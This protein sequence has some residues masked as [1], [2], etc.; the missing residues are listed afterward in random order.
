MFNAAIS[1][2]DRGGKLMFMRKSTEIPKSICNQGFTLI[3]V[4]IAMSIFAIGILAV[5]SMQV[6]AINKY[7][8]ARNSTTVVTVAKDRVEELN[9]LAYDDADLVAGE[10]SVSAGNLTLAT[11]GIDNDENGQIDEAGETGHI[12]IIWNVTETDLNGD[13]INDSKIVTV[14]VTR[15]TRGRQKEASLDFIRANM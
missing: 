14:T 12:S 1:A 6:S 2:F 11:D 13:G 9:G 7:A 4:L 10:H 5:G 3:E 15:A 8:G